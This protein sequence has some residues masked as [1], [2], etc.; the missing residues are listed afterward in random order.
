MK[1]SRLSKSSI[2]PAH[3]LPFLSQAEDIPV[4]GSFLAQ[5][6]QAGR[7][8]LSRLGVPTLVNLPRIWTV[9]HKAL[10]IQ[11]RQL[12][13]RESFISNIQRCLIFHRHLGFSE[14]NQEAANLGEQDT[15]LHLLSLLSTVCLFYPSLSAD[16]FSLFLRPH[17]RSPPP[18]K[19]LPV[20]FV[21]TN[22]GLTGRHWS[23][24]PSSQEK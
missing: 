23:P 18:P 2:A 4:V 12:K 8:S 21:Q 14:E 1:E 6:A 9:I 17:S 5:E 11:L 13:R 3:I 22:R 7:G 19:R 10:E 16:C 24:D 20:P 15:F